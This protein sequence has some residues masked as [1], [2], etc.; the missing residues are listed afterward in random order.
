MLL[1]HP[2]RGI[3]AAVTEWAADLASAGRRVL[4]PDLY[5]GRTAATIDEAE[6]LSEATLTDDAT[7]VFIQRCADELAAQEY[8][9][10]AMGFSMGAFLACSLAGRG[11]AG[12]NELILFYGG[13]P[14]EGEVSR[15]RRVVLHVAPGDDFFTDTELA[16]VKAGFGRQDPT[17][18]P[19]VTP[20]PVTG[21]PNA[22]RRVS[23]SPRSGWLAPG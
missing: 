12:P 7:F 17:C 15:T 19:I 3:T 22:A 9:W 14:P 16:A 5:G 6:A 4:V 2:W 10:A 11:A 23:T 1:L 8:P 20:A 21:S 18:R 13:Q